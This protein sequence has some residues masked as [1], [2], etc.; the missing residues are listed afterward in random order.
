MTL[1]RGVLTFRR[2][3]LEGE[4]PSGAAAL[5][6]RLE[7][8]RFRGSLRDASGEERSGWVPVEDLLGTAFEHG[9]TYRP[10]YLVFALRTDRKAIPPL[11]MRAMMEREIRALLDETGLERLPPGAR[12]EIRERIE[13]EYLPGQLPTVALTEVC[14]N[15]VTNRALV[16]ASSDK[17]VDRVRKHLSAS[18]SRVALPLGPARLAGR[19]DAEEAFLGREFLLWLWYR[20]EVGFG[21]LAGRSGTAVDLWVDD[22]LL[23]RG[24]GHEAQRFDLRGGA[25]A[26]S[27]TARTAVVEGRSV[28]A[29]RFG[30]RHEEREYS[31]ELHEDL[32]V[33][34][35]KLP[36]LDEETEDEILD[37]LTEVDLLTAHLDDLYAAFCDQR[38]G[39][40]WEDAIAPRI[41]GWLEE[42]VLGEGAGDT[43][44][45]PLD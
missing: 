14:W 17:A 29:A 9:A 36:D 25:P 7:Q 40:D 6:E 8:D 21:R 33:R 15:L 41:Q 26:A 3:E 20:S 10:P 27:A 37:R 32:S 38:L 42:A 19:D 13:E 44:S 43:V 28:H 31:F 35:L 22:R 34:G 11:L 23:I 4:P 18:F 16:M 24:E 45:D 39:P 30:L 2:F 12:D 1:L 5:I